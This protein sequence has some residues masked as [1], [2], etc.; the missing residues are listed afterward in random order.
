MSADLAF[1]I[2]LLNSSSAS[3]ADSVTNVTRIFYALYLARILVLR[4]F[5][6]CLPSDLSEAQARKEWLYFQIA[7]PP[8]SSGVDIFTAVFEAIAGGELK[9]LRRCADCTLTGLGWRNHKWFSKSFSTLYGREGAYVDVVEEGPPPLYIVV[10]EVEMP[11]SES[12]KPRT[13]RRAAR[14]RAQVYSL[15]CQPHSS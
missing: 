9:D 7:P 10:D 15:L 11:N 1:A 14:R 12:Q 13:V 6:D 4:R 5:L 3:T 2:K 8:I